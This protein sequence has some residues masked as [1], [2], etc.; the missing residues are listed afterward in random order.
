MEESSCFLF[1][2]VV[3]HSETKAISCLMG[4]AVCLVIYHAKA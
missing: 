3:Y 1:Q 2:G 4:A